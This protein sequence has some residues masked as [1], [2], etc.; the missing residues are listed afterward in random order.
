MEFNTLIENAKDTAKV[1][2]PGGWTQGRATFGGLAAAL[3]YQPMEAALEAATQGAIAETP[4]RSMT[5]S[6]VAPAAAG[7]L[8]TRSRVLRAGRSA[9]QIE[10]HASQGDQIVTAALASFGKP[11]QSTIAVSPD[12]APQ[13]RA[14]D[15]CEALPYIEGLVPEFTQHFD[16]RLAAGAFPFSGSS[17]PHLGGWIRFRESAGPVTTAHLLALIDAWPPAV[18]SML[19]DL[20]AASSLTWTLEMMPTAHRVKAERSADS[21]DWWQYLAE[22]EQ[23]EDGYGA[24]RARL[25]D[26]DGRLMALSRQTVTVFG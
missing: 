25:W 1:T 22:V 8:D 18:L 12:A 21:G 7:E 26:A 23:A 2:I 3:L 14:P 15:E 10:A 24:I 6:F 19:K 16:Y 5:I 20:A 11:R 4:L 9:V 13:F 17:E